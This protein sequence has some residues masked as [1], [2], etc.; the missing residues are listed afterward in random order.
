M[1]TRYLFLKYINY[2]EKKTIVTARNLANTILAKG[3]G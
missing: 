3:T 2:K 1:V